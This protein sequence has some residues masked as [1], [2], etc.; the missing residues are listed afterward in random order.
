V[1]V[2]K[3]GTV[4]F[5][6]VISDTEGG[7]FVYSEGTLGVIARTGAN[8]EGLGQVGAMARDVAGFASYH[9]GLNDKGQVVFPATVDGAVNLVVATPTP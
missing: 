5:V 1:V 8:I 7:A 4:A 3:D 9:L 6:A 2:N